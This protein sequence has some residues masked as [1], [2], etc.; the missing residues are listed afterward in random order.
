MTKHLANDTIVLMKAPKQVNVHYA[1]TQL[2]RLLADVE[3]GREIVVARSGTPVAKL[4]PWPEPR[5]R[6]LRMGSWKGRIRISADFDAPLSD[7]DL[8]DWGL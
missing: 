5:A 6:T 4:V 1:K 8:R 2:S 3:R 7:R